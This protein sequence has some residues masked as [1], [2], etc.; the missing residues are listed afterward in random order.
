MLG[1]RRIGGGS[2]RQSR[3]YAYAIVSLG[4]LNVLG[5][6]GFLR[7]GYTM[8]LPSIREELGLNYTQTGLLATANYV[9][10]F[11]GALVVGWLVVRFGSRWTIGL[12]SLAVGGAMVLTGLARGYE[13]LLGL[14]LVAGAAGLWATSPSV[15]LATAWFSRE[16]RGTATGAMSVGAPLGSLITG[17]LMPFFLLTFGLV[18]WRYGWAS[19]GAAVV[20]FGALS[21]I[22]LRNRPSEVGLLPLGAAPGEI[23]PPA[24]GPVN[25]GLVY[26]SPLVWYLSLLGLA[27][28]LSNISFTTFFTIYLLQERAL[29]AETAGRLWAL[30]GVFGIVGG[31]LWGWIS[32]RASR[33]TALVFSFMVQALSFALFASNWGIGVFVL[34]AFLFG[35]TSRANYAVMAAFCGDLLGPRLAA[36][37]F[38]VNNLMAGV[39]LAIGPAAAGLIADSTNSFTPAFLASA[40]VALLGALGSALL[41][42]ERPTK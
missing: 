11:L 32:D 4:L 20:L 39:G 33:K 31:F 17:F 26:R 38:G 6:Q 18:G 8:T 22:W 5:A 1:K 28:T 19:L 35:I 34:C 2:E 21:L 9:G 3:H 29:D 14:Q 23:E 25:W 24:T 42:V 40:I 30:A 36:A 7:F 37:A 16:R 27:A 12:A 41:R 13:V 15:A 10:Y